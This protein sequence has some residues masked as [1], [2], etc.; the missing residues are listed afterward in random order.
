MSNL[1]QRYVE[2][3]RPK[4]KDEMGVDNIMQVPR[5]QKVTLNM[6]VEVVTQI[7]MPL[8]RSI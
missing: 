1:Y 8:M 5:L 2:E 6:G 4:L 3:V 7:S